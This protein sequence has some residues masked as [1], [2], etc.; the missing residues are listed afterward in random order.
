MNKVLYSG[1]YLVTGMSAIKLTGV[2]RV[3]RLSS[4]T[5]WGYPYHSTQVA[6][7][8]GVILW[9]DIILQAAL[10]CVSF[11][12]TATFQRLHFCCGHLPG[13]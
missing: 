6:S 4:V 10:A 3:S 9:V 11:G 2:T 7:G 5:R 8:S 13:D 1:Q 12:L